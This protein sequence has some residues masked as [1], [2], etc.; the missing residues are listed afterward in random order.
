MLGF[1]VGKLV[2]GVC[3]LESIAVTPD[4][5]GQGIGRALLVAVA[6]WAQANAA[7]RIELEVR[8]SNIRAIKLY[9]RAGLR[10]E[11]LTASLL[12]VARGGRGPHGQGSGSWWKTSLKNALPVEPP[13]W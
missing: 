13:E 4:F 12:P 11:G 6:D 7:T 5:R 9:E 3:D 8:A 2:A 10:R 1:S